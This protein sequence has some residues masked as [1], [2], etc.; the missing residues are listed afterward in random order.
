VKFDTSGPLG[1]SEPRQR[2]LLVGHARFFLHATR[3]L[4]APHLEE[5]EL[6]GMR[7]IEFD[8]AGIE[9]GIVYS[10]IN[11]SV[12]TLDHSKDSE[13]H[14]PF[15]WAL[16]DTKG[17]QLEPIN[18]RLDYWRRKIRKIDAEFD[19]RQR[20]ILRALFHGYREPLRKGRRGKS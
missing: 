14:V 12:V 1:I 2:E 9:L 8:G 6:K 18:E 7:T 19:F 17:R 4:H 5:V 10:Q 11:G 20:T 13:N 16:M 15:G 3:V